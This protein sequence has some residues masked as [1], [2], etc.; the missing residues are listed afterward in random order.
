MMA[1]AAVK[2]FEAQ[3]ARATGLK[4]ILAPSTLK[5]PG[6]HVKLALRKVVVPKTPKAAQA[7]KT[8]RLFAVV[9]GSAES[10]T[11]LRLALE[12]CEAMAD[13]LVHCV[14]LE[15]ETGTAIA[16]TRIESTVN[17]DDGILQDPD[18]GNIA[19]LDDTHFVSITI[20]A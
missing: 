13:Y 16:D 15:D 5:E 1:F 3:L 4:V 2:Y 18:N 14:R 19:W 20:P 6:P 7:S 11:G 17:E 8:V 10:E 12:A 9:D